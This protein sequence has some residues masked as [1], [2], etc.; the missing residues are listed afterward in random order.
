[1]QLEERL[2][3]LERQL[4]S[5]S[6]LNK[7]QERILNRLTS[8]LD[9]QRCPICGQEFDVDEGCKA[10]VD[11]NITVFCNNPTCSK[12]KIKIK[13]TPEVRSVLSYLKSCLT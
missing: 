9:Y 12:Y 4:K 8:S 2:G 13:L 10:N 7:N 1:M 11:F 6:Q 5:L 3:L